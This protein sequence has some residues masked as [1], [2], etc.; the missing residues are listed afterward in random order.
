MLTR[1][2]LLTLAFVVAS[3]MG[4]GNVAVKPAE[5]RDAGKILAGIAAGALVYGLLDQADRSSRVEPQHRGYYDGNRG[6]WTAPRKSA[7][8]YRPAPRPSPTYQRGY[9]HGHRDG[10]NRGYDRGHYDGYDRGYDHG[11]RDGHDYGR[12]PWGR[13]GF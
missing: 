1:S 12:S 13:W 3:T 6:A 4:M 11:F 7:P 5:A 8:V 2:A 10:F 9:D